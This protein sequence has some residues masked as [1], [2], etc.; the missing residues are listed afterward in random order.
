MMAAL[1][2][3]DDD[4]CLFADD[5]LREIQETEWREGGMAFR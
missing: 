5:I 1:T 4:S 2:D 3:V